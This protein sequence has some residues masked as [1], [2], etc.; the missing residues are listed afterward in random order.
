MKAIVLIFLSVGLLI[1]CS[2]QKQEQTQEAEKAEK[3]NQIN[4]SAIEL[5]D[6]EGN[7]IRWEDLKGKTIFLNFWAT[8]CKPCI[9]EMPSMDKAYQALK[10]EDFIFMAAS[11]EEPEKIRSFREKQEFSFPLVHMKTSLEA[12][13]IYSIPTTFII[14]KEGELARIV[15]GSRQWDAPETLNELKQM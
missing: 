13:N 1:G 10:E 4:V 12:L 5:V 9:M 6:L 15:V 7:P 8:W 3:E 2:N 14:N 11:Y